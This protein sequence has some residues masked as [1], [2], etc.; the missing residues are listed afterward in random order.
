MIDSSTNSN[1]PDSDSSPSVDLATNSNIYLN[2]SEIFGNSS[3]TNSNK[4]NDHYSAAYYSSADNYYRNLHYSH[5][6]G[7]HQFHPPAYWLHA[8]TSTSEQ[9]VNSWPVITSHLAS[10]SNSNSST[11]S[12][13]S[14]YQMPPLNTTN[15][16]APSS[17]SVS[18]TTASASSSAAN[19]PQS[20][21]NNQQILNT[22]LSLINQDA[23]NSYITS[24]AS[25]FNMHSQLVNAYQSYT[26]NFGGIQHLPYNAHNQQS[27]LYPP[28]PPKD[29][30]NNIGYSLKNKHINEPI[31]LLA[32]S[33]T[34]IDTVKNEHL[35]ISPAHNVEATSSVSPDNSLTASID[36]NKVKTEVVT[37]KKRSINQ[38]EKE[39]QEINGNSNENTSED[40]DE[41]EENDD[42]LEGADDDDTNP[43][44]SE[45][46]EESTSNSPSNR[47]SF[48]PNNNQDWSISSKNYGGNY[49]SIKMTEQD[50]WAHNSN[51]SSVSNVSNKRKALPGNIFISF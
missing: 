21:L 4:W 41:Y 15:L 39:E 23:S 32:I 35:N 13:N 29:V 46:L 11:H 24:A 18:S 44:N 27:P 12:N 5:Q 49:S 43:D 37:N 10:S 40:E 30:N 1:Q 34:L 16:T 47:N 19:T 20:H 42:G 7:H 36:S 51:K 9:S 45:S 48:I 50:K 33:Q 8:A 25:N 38:T 2:N 6:S 22:K 3:S 28:T 14:Y 17:S 26:N 31:S